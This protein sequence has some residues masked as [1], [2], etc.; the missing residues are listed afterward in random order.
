MHRV[1][2][3]ADLFVIAAASIGPAFSLA[4]IFGPMV[5]VGGS[6][7]PLAL[8]IVAAIMIC[9]ALAYRRLGERHPDAGSAYAWVRIAFG[10]AAGAYAGWVLIVA[11]IFAVVATSMPAGT[12]TLSLLAPGL[13][14]TPFADALVGAGWVLAAGTL[15]Y[16]GLRP[17][18]RVTYVLLVAEL[19]ILAVVATAA[20]LH[21]VVSHAVA[22]VALP[23]VYALVPAIVIGIWMIDGWEV[24]ASTAEESEGSPQTPG[25][26]GLTG[27]LVSAAVLGLC[28][29]AFMRVGTLDGYAAHVGDAMGFV[30][31]ILGGKAWRLAISIVVL[32]SLAA[33]LQ[34]T[35]VYLTRSFFALGRDRVLPGALGRLDHRRQPAAGVALITILGIVFTLVSG[36]SPTLKM[37]FDFIL[38]GTSFFL[39][40]LFLMSAAAAVRI[41]ASERTARID[42]MLLPGLAVVALAVVLGFSLV[43]GT[44]GNRIFIL[45]SAAVGIPLAWWRGRASAAIV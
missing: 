40:A 8:A 16:F 13:V 27:L 22:T 25:L 28:M 45:G 42:G 24:S 15:L 44:L 32:V 39:G 26:G 38:G 34:T 19:V 14:D 41:F 6:G 5:A 9:V 31:S 37:A 43:Q 10:P 3:L 36:L 30:G 29:T 4:T 12:Y 21:P 17:T 20:L 35:L 7:T 11:N 2:K 1:L 23:G 33:S 18:A